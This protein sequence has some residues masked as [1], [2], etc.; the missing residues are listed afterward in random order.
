MKSYY[1][2]LYVLFLKDWLCDTKILKDAEATYVK[3]LWYWFPIANTWLL[4]NVM[5]TLLYLI[6]KPKDFCFSKDKNI[7]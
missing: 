1:D 2:V 7:A 3:S 5:G 4:L 6:G